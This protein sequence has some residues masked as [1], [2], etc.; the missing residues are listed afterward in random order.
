MTSSN[1]K[2][3]RKTRVAQK[4]SVCVFMVMLISGLVSSCAQKQ[5]SAVVL[6]TALANG[7]CE[8]SNFRQLTNT[9]KYVGGPGQIICEPTYKDYGQFE[10][11]VELKTFFSTYNRQVKSIKSDADAIRA[12]QDYLAFFTSDSDGRNCSIVNRHIN[13]RSFGY[14]ALDESW[15]VR[16]E[17]VNDGGSYRMYYLDTDWGIIG[18]VEYAD[19]CPIG[20]IPPPFPYGR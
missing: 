12:V 16:A 14:S 2:H 4:V 19:G 13:W 3:G 5:D 8:T 11:N 9:G 10:R 17:L 7:N 15:A 1:S 20:H 18:G 6:S